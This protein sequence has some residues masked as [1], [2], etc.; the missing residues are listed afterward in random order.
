MQPELDAAVA[1]LCSLL[2]AS[3]S[4]SARTRFGASLLASLRPRLAASSWLAAEPERGSAAR[5][6][7]WH[8][9]AGG[10]GGDAALRQACAAAALAPRDALPALTLWIDPGCVSMRL[11][12]GPGAA[13][14]ERSAA[15]APV[16]LVWGA[17]PAALAPSPRSTHAPLQRSGEHAYRTHTPTPLGSSSSS[18]SSWSA[19]A[20]RPVRIVDPSTLSRRSPPPPPPHIRSPSACSV[21]TSCASSAFGSSALTRSVSSSSSAYGTSVSS[22]S[23]PSLLAPGDDGSD[24]ELS[25]DDLDAGSCYGIIDLIDD[26]SDVC[27]ES[28]VGDATLM[29]STTNDND[30]DTT[31]G[32]SPSKAS[33]VSGAHAW[34]ATQQQQHKRQSPSGAALNY[35]V[36]DNGNVGVLG[37]G[38]R[39]GGAPAKSVSSAAAAAAPAHSSLLRHTF[40]AAARGFQPQHQAVEWTVPP[41]ASSLCMLPPPQHMALSPATFGNSAYPQLP[42]PPSFYAVPPPPQLLFSN[43]AAAAFQRAPPQPM[44]PAMQQQQQQQ[45][46]QYPG[47]EGHQ[48]PP[49]FAAAYHGLPHAG[50]FLGLDPCALGGAAPMKRVRSRGRRSRGRGAGR[51]ARRQAAALKALAERDGLAPPSGSELG[52][53]YDDDEGDDDES[54]GDDRDIERRCEAAAAAAANANNA[55]ASSWAPHARGLSA[56]PR[57]AAIGTF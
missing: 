26:E 35:T 21:A 54:D 16:T 34:A 29:C 39:L 42:M 10:E 7:L 12:P 46:Q 24:S 57:A 38:V 55:N 2:P 1:Q 48:A 8:E 43:H 52:D 6:L 45:Q 25:V 31:V 11:G 15:G 56:T 22:A 20:P 14:S 5:A 53:E 49:P 44:L 33:A 51:A 30:G 32:A 17:L 3:T 9:H 41:P 13:D 28:D 50:A 4:A 37:G 18:S 19:S 40:N 23:C 36:H 47:V 27:D